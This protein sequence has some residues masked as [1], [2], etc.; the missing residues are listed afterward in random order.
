MMTEAI[1]WWSVLITTFFGGWQV[2]W[3]Y[4]NGF[5]FPGGAHL[6]VCRISS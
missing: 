4:P 6:G 1:V 2:P 3:L 5:H